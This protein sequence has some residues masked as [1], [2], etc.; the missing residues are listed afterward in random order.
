MPPVAREYRLEEPDGWGKAHWE[1]S[2]DRLSV[3]GQIRIADPILDLGFRLVSDP[4]LE[5]RHSFP[6][7]VEYPRLSLS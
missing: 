7:S 3:T 4:G 6:R 5:N 1:G 2:G